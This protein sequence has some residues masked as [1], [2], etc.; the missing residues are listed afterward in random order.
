M[1][2][3]YNILHKI[4]NT[5]KVSNSYEKDFNK[6]I[7]NT[8]LSFKNSDPEIEVQK[9]YKDRVINRYTPKKTKK[10]NLPLF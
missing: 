5:I 1:N 7:K 9:N 4:Q 2:V 3:K 6:N 10:Y 8:M